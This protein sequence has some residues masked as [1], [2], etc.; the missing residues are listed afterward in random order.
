M[1]SVFPKGA[2]YTDSYFPDVPVNSGKFGGG[3]WAA[4]GCRTWESTTP[5]DGLERKK[6]YVWARCI[7]DSRHWSGG[8]FFAPW[9]VGPWALLEWRYGPPHC[10]LPV[11]CDPNDPNVGA[12]ASKG[13]VFPKITTYIME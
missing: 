10:Y 6:H 5:Y 9:T 3:S 7:V 2:N 11:Q 8:I 1:I 4:F 12:V 13:T